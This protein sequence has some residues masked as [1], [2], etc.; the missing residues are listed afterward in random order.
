MTIMRDANYLD[1]IFSQVN[2]NLLDLNKSVQPIT[3]SLK[4]FIIHTT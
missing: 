4:S 3:L 2:L 1:P